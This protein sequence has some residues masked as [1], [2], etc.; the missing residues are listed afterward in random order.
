MVH[1]KLK[2]EI[3]E[4]FTKRKKTSLLKHLFFFKQTN[5]KIFNHF[6]RLYL[7][8]ADE[9]IFSIK[10]N[11]KKCQMLLKNTNFSGL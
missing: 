8:I 3:E 4:D 6:S 2:G 9:V 7:H 1:S 11:I 5:L 10:R